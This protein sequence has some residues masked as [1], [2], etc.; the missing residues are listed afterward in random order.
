LPGGFVV[1]QHLKNLGLGPALNAGIAE[2]RHRGATEIIL[3]DQDSTPDA[4]FVL[5]MAAQ[6]AKGQAAHGNRCC[7]GPTHLDDDTGTAVS[8]HWSHR[9]DAVLP[10]TQLVS[11]L[12]TSGLIFSVGALEIPDCFSRD[13]FLDLADFEWCWRLGAKGWRF[14]RSREVFMLHRL[15]IKERRVLGMT[16]HVPEPYRHYFQVRDALKLAF[17]DYV[18]VY[19]KWRLIGILP[20][21]AFVYPFLL[22]RGRERLQ[23]MVRGAYDGFRGVAGIGSAASRLGS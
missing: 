20:L 4:S 6:L 1:L 17:L 8:G 15:G 16:L 14:L 13:F 10:A 23:W 19:S 5:A 22:D 7:V 3:F 12:P 9:P 11:C 18:P 21:K 2:A